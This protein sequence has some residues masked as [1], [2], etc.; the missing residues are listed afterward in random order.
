MK[1]EKI[2]ILLLGICLLIPNT[3]F[4]E[5]EINEEIGVI[6]ERIVKDDLKYPNYAET[7]LGEDKYENFNRK[8]FDMNLKMNKYFLKP[9]HIVWASIMPQYG[10]DRIQ[11]V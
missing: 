8:I 7:Y 9:I 1:K 6:T 10:M 5:V 11:S 4:A 2:I 3:S